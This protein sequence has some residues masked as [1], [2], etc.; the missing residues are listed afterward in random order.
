[1]GDTA[2]FATIPDNF[3]VTKIGDGCT[4]PPELRD[5]LREAVL[6]KCRAQPLWFVER[7]WQVI[8]PLSMK[9]VPFE[10]R[11]YQR[12]DGEWFVEAMGGERARRIV[13]KARQIG[14]TTLAAALVVWDCLFNDNHPWLIASQ[15]EGDA[16]ATLITRS[17]TPYSRLPAWMKE[18]LPQLT[19]D[20]KE[21]MEFDNGSS[22]LSIPA[23]S[24]AGRSKVA[25]GVLLDEAAFADNATE[26][27]GGLDPLCYGP[28][29]VFSTANGMGNFFHRTWVEAQRPDTEWGCRFRAWWVVPHRDEKWYQREKLKSRGMEWQFFQEYPSTPEEAFAKTGRTVLNIEVL[30]A[31]MCF[32]EPALRY[33]L[34]MDEDFESP[35]GDLDEAPHELHVWAPP[36]V[37]RDEHGRV[38]QKPNY[39][40]GVDI[41]EG[42]DHGDRTSIDVVDANTGHQVASYL[43]HWPVEALGELVARIGYWYHTALLLP[44]RNNAGIL[45]IADLQRMGYPRI[46]R[47]GHLAAIPKSDKTPR[48][49]W[50]TNRSTKPKSVNELV[51][52][53]ATGAIVI[54]DARFL[55]E[56]HTFIHDGKGGM[57][58][59][60]GNH[61]DKIMS[62]TIANQGLIH[63]G[64]YPIVWH[65]DSVPLTTMGDLVKL[66]FG[67]PTTNPLSQRIGQDRRSQSVRE[68][69]SV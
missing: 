33:D 45:P 64:A 9:W 4:L 63:V 25:Y 49:G 14:W 54:H 30:Q 38:V 19:N 57:N 16:Q 67:K 42:L 56:A 68:S 15:T 1:M 43:G 31:E 11:D 69:F 8:D 18:S 21:S 52:A 17:K 53:T 39:V 55:Q 34:L 10:L 24:S 60:E 46:W 23:S 44:E 35:L 40:I 66:G 48:Y 65:D 13:L 32:C 27:F 37:L 62:V 41:A 2:K 22:I 6:R 20:N 5:A 58:A 26:L 28:M 47:M 7:F 12:E 50:Q 29:F 36:E 3:D 59:S 61:D 51:R